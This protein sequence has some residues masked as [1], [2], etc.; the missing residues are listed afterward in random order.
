M[1]N[2]FVKALYSTL[3]F[4]NKQQYVV[5]PKKKLNA[6]SLE[7]SLFYGYKI[8]AAMD[9]ITLALV[10]SGIIQYYC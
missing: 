6:Y 2:S 1:Q 10:L 7:M 4:Q 9:Y 5:K 8:A 3:F